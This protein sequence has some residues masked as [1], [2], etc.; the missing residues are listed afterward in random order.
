MTVILPRLPRAVADE[1]LNGFRSGEPMEPSQSHPAQ[2]FAPLGRRATA[3]EISS[4]A[5]R[6]ESTARRFGFPAKLE[7][8]RRIEFDRECAWE[9]Y[10]EL[11]LPW[12]EAGSPDVWSFIALV[13]MPDLTEWRFGLRNAERWIGSDLTRHT[14]ARAW[15]RGALFFD[16]RPTF[17][18]LSESDLNQL[19]ERRSI[20][21]DPR[22]VAQLAEATLLVPS[23][24]GLPRRAVIRDAAKRLRRRLAFVDV[25]ALDD[26]ELELACSSAVMETVALL[27]PADIEADPLTDDD[28]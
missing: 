27:T 2:I 10:D 24:S 5:E 23:E 21:G 19:L 7:G 16:H 26:A 20:G 18:R 15:W 22:L 8:G 9:I 12:S 25:R 6:I 4:L 17:E 11:R 28:E 13:A 14:W 3:E 1:L